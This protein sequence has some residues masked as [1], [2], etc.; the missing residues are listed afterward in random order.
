MK[1]LRPKKNG[2]MKKS[3]YVNSELQKKLAELLKSRNK[4]VLLK[5][6]KS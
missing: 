2:L 6:T 5:K 3:A 1:K 4:D